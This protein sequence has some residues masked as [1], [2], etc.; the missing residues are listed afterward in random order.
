MG[1]ASAVHG[2]WGRIRNYEAQDLWELYKANRQLLLKSILFEN[3]QFPFKVVAVSGNSY[4]HLI[5]P[6][7]GD[8]LNSAYTKLIAA[9][10]KEIE[11]KYGRGTSNVNIDPSKKASSNLSLFKK[12][13]HKNVKE[14]SSRLGPAFSANTIIQNSEIIRGKSSNAAAASALAGLLLGSNLANRKVNS[15]H[16]NYLAKDKNI[17]IILKILMSEQKTSLIAPNLGTAFESLIVAILGDVVNEAKDIAAQTIINKIKKI[18][19]EKEGTSF[20]PLKNILKGS[21][22]KVESKKIAITP[23]IQFFY[24]SARNRE[25]K[26]IKVSIKMASDPASIKY[27]S[28]GGKDG[29]IWTEIAHWSKVLK[30]FAV[31]TSFYPELTYLQ[32]YFGAMLASLA[33]GGIK[34]NR[35]LMILTMSNGSIR[36]KSLDVV[37]SEM[38]NGNRMIMNRIKARNE[39][40]YI[41]NARVI[42]S[43]RTING[44]SVLSGKEN[45]EQEIYG[46]YSKLKDINLNFTLRSR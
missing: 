14:L 4:V 20:V 37:L 39:S 31:W 30:T 5:V 43:G 29:E 36:L 35:A 26:K 7:S 22:E 13:M 42:A 34:E 12:E 19:A 8:V 32:E 40:S 46:K 38:K 28:A 6:G 21:Q 3:S 16:I 11:G 33:I 23:D 2:N 45:L 18:G 27:K 25:A 41:H 44:Q 1:R 15:E 9:A 10:K 17:E 24:Q